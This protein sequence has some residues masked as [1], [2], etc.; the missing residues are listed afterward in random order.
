M[1]SKSYKDQILRLYVK[2]FVKIY[3]MNR[4]KYFLLQENIKIGLKE[5]RKRSFFDPTP[6]ESWEWWKY[7]QSW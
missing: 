4:L 2:I 3:L 1:G 6:E 7:N 5:K